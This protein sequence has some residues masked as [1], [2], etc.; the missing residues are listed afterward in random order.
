[1]DSF[2]DR[3][4][5]IG[6]KVGDAS[7][8]AAKKTSEVGSSIAEDIKVGAK[9]VSEDVKVGAK[10]VSETVE[11]KRDEFKEK[12]EESKK[13]KAEADDAREEELRSVIKSTDLIPI[14]PINEDGNE[15]ESEE[16]IDKLTVNQLKSRLSDLGLKVSGKKS[17]LADRLKESLDSTKERIAEIR[18]SSNDEEEHTVIEEIVSDEPL[19]FETKNIENNVSNRKMKY[20]INWLNRAFFGY[21]IVLCL[22]VLGFFS[23]FGILEEFDFIGKRFIGDYGGMEEIWSLTLQIETAICLFIAGLLYLFGKVKNAAVLSVF[24][25]LFSV[26]YRFYFA[27]QS[28]TMNEFGI[29]DALVDFVSLSTFCVTSAVPWFFVSDIEHLDSQD[30]PGSIPS[31]HDNQSEELMF[32]A[33]DGDSEDMDQFAVTRPTPPRRRRPMEFFYEGIFLLIGLVLWPIT[34]STHF[35]LA[36]EIPTRYGTWDMEANALTLLVPLY[37]LSFLAT[38]VVIRSDREARGGALYAKEKEAYHEFMNQFLALK[39]AYYERQAKRLNLD[40]SE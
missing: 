40:D 9:K 22:S 16:Q 6:Q 39:K 13:A 33:L 11:Q 36:L 12:R 31:I 18:S 23:T 20:A 35:L 17:E 19:I 27:L 24:I 2:K 29:V 10:K 21:Y 15:S 5:D 8:K 28:G 37:L 34:I 32:D 1:M 7:K 30:Y 25:A 26:I 14:S 4:S 3:L 38:W